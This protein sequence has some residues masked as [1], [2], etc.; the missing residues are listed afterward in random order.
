MDAGSLR[1][2][3]VG[4]L[5]KIY[6]KTSHNKLSVFLHYNLIPK[7]ENHILIWGVYESRCVDVCIFGCVYSI[8]LE[9]KFK[10]VAYIV[11]IPVLYF[12]P[13]FDKI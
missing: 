12:F 7:G 9:R 8:R 10:G 13:I 6:H 11:K 2:T 3:V 1:V 4:L 5:M